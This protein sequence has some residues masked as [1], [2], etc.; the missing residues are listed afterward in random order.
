M[1]LTTTKFDEGLASPAQVWP[2]PVPFHSCFGIPEDMLPRAAMR[3]TSSQCPDPQPLRTH[4]LARLRLRVAAR[5]RQGILEERFGQVRCSKRIMTVRQWE[6]VGTEPQPRWR[7]GVWS[8]P[9]KGKAPASISKAQKLDMRMARRARAVTMTKKESINAPCFWKDALRD[10]ERSKAQDTQWPAQW[11]VF[12]NELKPPLPAY[13]CARPGSAPG[14]IRRDIPWK[15]RAC[16]KKG[17]SNIAG[18]TCRYDMRGNGL[19]QR[20]CV[21]SRCDGLTPTIACKQSAL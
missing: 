8:P 7:K 17:R 9:G 14:G 6:A 19:R 5:G 13:F 21:P 12:R 18:D 10:M 4:C 15:Q 11:V 3:A 2:V 1:R 16:A 20:S